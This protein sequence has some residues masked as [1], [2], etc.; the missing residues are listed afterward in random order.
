MTDLKHWGEHKKGQAVPFVAI[1]CASAQL[2]QVVGD[3]KPG[4]GPT[5]LCVSV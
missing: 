3:S 2:R 5:E 1:A 4:S